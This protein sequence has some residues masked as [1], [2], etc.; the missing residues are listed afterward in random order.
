MQTIIFATNNEN[1]VREIRQMLKGS[2]NVITLKEAGISACIEENGETFE[3]NALIKARHIYNLTKKATISDDSGLCIDYLDGK[4][5]VHSARFMGEDT[6]YQVKN[7]EILRL[8]SD[9]P[10]DKRGAKF[11]CVMAFITEEG[12]EYLVRGEMEG[13]ISEKIAGENGF[14]YDPIFYLDE[15]EKTA[16]ELSSTQKNEISHRGLALR[17]LKK[18]IDKMEAE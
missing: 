15:Y 3:E 12:E 4:P 16:A 14:G 13:R 2:F 17:G 18:I 7:E 6:S 10:N 11:V 9:V 5:G 1:K 8:L